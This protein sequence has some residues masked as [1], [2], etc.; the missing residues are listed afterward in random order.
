MS[1]EYVLIG[2]HEFAIHVPGLPASPAGS[3]NAPTSDAADAPV[4]APRR[5]SEP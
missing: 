2:D 1:T 3:P 5:R 4:Q